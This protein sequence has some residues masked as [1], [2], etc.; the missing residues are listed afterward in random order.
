[1]VA[2]GDARKGFIFAGLMVALLCAV[3]PVTAL[4]VDY[5]DHGELSIPTYDS[6][7]RSGV[8]YYNGSVWAAAVNG[9]GLG[10]FEL[11]ENLSP[12]SDGYFISGATYIIGQP[13]GGDWV[14]IYHFGSK[15]IT[16]F[17]MSSGSVISKFSTS[18]YFPFFGVRSLSDGKV[19]IL[20]NYGGRV[21]VIDSDGTKFSEF[22]APTSGSELSKMVTYQDKI[23]LFEKAQD[24]AHGYSNQDYK[25]HEYNASGSE[26]SNYWMNVS[27]EIEEPFDEGSY[28]RKTRWC[29]IA[30]HDNY[31]LLTVRYYDYDKIFAYDFVNGNIVSNGTIE[32][33]TFILDKTCPNVVENTAEDAVYYFAH[34]YSGNR[35]VMAKFNASDMSFI[36]ARGVSLHNTTEGDFVNF[37]DEV[38]YKTPVVTGDGGAALLLGVKTLDGS[39]ETYNFEWASGFLYTPS[40]LEWLVVQYNGTNA[41]YE[42]ITS[43]NLEGVWVDIAPPVIVSVGSKV[44]V[45][46]LEYSQPKVVWYEFNF[47]DGNSDSWR[48]GI[49]ESSSSRSFS[50]ANSKKTITEVQSDFV[51]YEFLFMGHHEQVNSYDY[52]W[53]NGTYPNN[54]PLFLNHSYSQLSFYWVEGNNRISCVDTPQ[55]YDYTDKME[56]VGYYSGSPDNLQY[57]VNYTEHASEDV[58][59]YFL[60]C[61]HEDCLFK[62]AAYG[63]G[64]SCEATGAYVGETGSVV[65]FTGQHEFDAYIHDKSENCSL[66]DYEGEVYI[67]GNKVK[68][69]TESSS[70]VVVTLGEG[71][72]NITVVPTA[73]PAMSSPVL[74]GN[75]FYT[76]YSNG[77]ASLD[78]TVEYVPRYSAGDFPKILFDGI[79]GVVSELAD[80]SEVIAGAA[81]LGAV[82]YAFVVIL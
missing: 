67:D 32:A 47:T 25:I 51:D 14:P 6:V 4:N 77:T 41:K 62:Q 18:F 27:A 80:N 58:N 70:G 15:E 69:I 10:L 1:M 56:V 9:S 5:T 12:V 76:F 72:H 59:G 3:A 65:S 39:P 29:E 74:G 34:T 61:Y 38:T 26:L 13:E 28:V 53:C 23:Y 33:S 36:D 78:M 35:L 2:T 71:A 24:P 52:G 20:D 44:Y 64:L 30:Q 75:P 63:L 8:V 11:D 22:F 48:L 81:L 21:V 54:L 57:R 82:T 42:H 45:S 46:A 49:S 37:F 17:N 73:T 7:G 68:D 31:V 16:T 60:S 40:K 66:T 50:F 19:A 55:V 79:G 43:T